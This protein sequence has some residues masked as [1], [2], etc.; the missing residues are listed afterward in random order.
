MAHLILHV[1]ETQK[2]LTNPFVFRPSQLNTLTTIMAKYLQRSILR[3][4]REGH[5]LQVLNLTQQPRPIILNQT[6]TPLV[7]INLQ[8]SP[9]SCSRVSHKYTNKKSP[10]NSQFHFSF[11]SFTHTS[12]VAYMIYILIQVSFLFMSSCCTHNV[13]NLTT[14]S[15]IR[16]NCVTT[17]FLI[18]SFCFVSTCLL[19]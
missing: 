8:R 1:K 17:S 2:S 3:L 16:P 7:S 13:Y 11:F 6:K 10:R 9:D 5:K 19:Y 14:V 4:C 12:T 18:V 15:P